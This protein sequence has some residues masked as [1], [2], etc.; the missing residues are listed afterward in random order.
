LVNFRRRQSVDIFD[1]RCW[2]DG[3]R[4]VWG[5]L[6]AAAQSG[7]DLSS[8]AGSEIMAIDR[9]EQSSDRLCCVACGREQTLMLPVVEAD[10]RQRPFDLYRCEDCGL[11]Q[12][13]PRYTREQLRALYGADYY[14]FA[15][16]EAHRWSRAV[17]QYV[18]HLL[19][20]ESSQGRR[21]LDVGSGLGHLAALGAARGWRVTG[22]DLS[23]EAVSQASER[24]GLDFRAG[25]LERFRGT[26]PPFDVA[27]LGDVMEHVP[28]PRE[29]LGEVR[30]G[31]IPGGVVCIDT[32]NWG[33]RWRWVGGSRW[34]GLNRFHINLFEAASL[35]RL[36]AECG[37]E[38]VH[39]ASSTHYRY[40]SWA[41]RPELQ[42]IVGRLPR[43]LGW[44][45]NRRL[46]R[47]GARKP[48]AVLRSNPP[49]TL[50]DAGREVTQLADLSKTPEQ[51]RLSADNLIAFA[52]RA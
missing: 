3:D 13:H 31:L 22:V 6:A 36:L 16:D 9:Q 30:A 33:G 26:L 44:R 42:A 11:V 45:I 7:V 41:D 51:A 19:R 48:W 2:W 17:Q 46:A 50:E 1:K 43:F 29:F 32:P 24:F 5:P 34:V 38:D 49:T 27:F 20:W 23:A 28:R 8:F 35:G 40:E 12:Q 52:R 21:L 4:G 10:L 18:V 25:P 39:F 14:V 37:F 15:E 47:R